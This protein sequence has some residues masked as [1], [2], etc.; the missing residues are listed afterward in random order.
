VQPNYYFNCYPIPCKPQCELLT[1]V[2]FLSDDQSA[3]YQFL[4]ASE[5][6]FVIVLHQGHSFF[7]HH[8]YFNLDA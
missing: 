7:L 6:S 1:S 8:L 4:T 2:L 5:V 3:I